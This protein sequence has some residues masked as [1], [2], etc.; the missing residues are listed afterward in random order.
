MFG[1]FKKKS[2]ADKLN[3]KYEKLLAQ[4][5]ALSTSNRAESDKIYAEAQEVLK[6]I[7]KLEE[8]V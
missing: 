5:Y 3:E 8:N 4:S 7:E 1:M 6:E 2:A